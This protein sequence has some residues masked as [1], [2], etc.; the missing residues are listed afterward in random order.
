MLRDG[1]AR[2]FGLT[3]PQE[4]LIQALEALPTDQ[5]D[6]LAA[7]LRSAAE[8]GG[9]VFLMGNGG[10]FDNARLIAALLR[11]RG[12]RAKLPGDPDRYLEA[13]AAADYGAIFVKGLEDD[14][15][16]PED[17]A[18]GISGS[19]NSPNVVRALEYAKQIG[20][21]TL[22]LGGR[23]GGR[24]RRVVGD[25]RCL[26]AAATEMEMIEDL[27]SLI[28]AALDK[29]LAQGL[30]AAEVVGTLVAALRRLLG[31]SNIDRFADL[32]SEMIRRLDNQ[33]R[34]FV[35]GT[36]LSLGHFRADAQRGFT[37]GVPIRG[38]CAPELFTINSGMATLNDDGPSF[39]IA[40]GLV[41]FSP[42]SGDFAVLFALGGDQR[43]LKPARD[44]LLQGHTPFLEVGRTVTGIDFS[45][46][47]D[48]F[49]AEIVPTVCGHACGVVIN[50]WL[51][52][53]FRVRRL[54]ALKLELG[55]DRKLNADDTV[56]LERRLREE[57]TLAENE[58][59][60][61]QYGEA[62]AAKDPA[63][64]G[65]ERVYY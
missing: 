49:D 63:A 45:P 60:C 65:L 34:L 26:L 56:R 42:G 19:G 11:R 1:F 27:H 10:S 14:R 48:A 28:G 9:A 61:F 47:L 43:V 52:E 55:D 32:A 21:A 41:K 44:L 4:G 36:A 59:I 5:I 17:L 39:L 37:N 57:G 20:A 31:A 46:V 22:G 33:G 2:Y 54:P 51:R 13:T 58:V 8:K 23:D 30:T 64:F 40:D 3:H 7:D 25:R 15:I 29:I 35:I 18:I 38:F 12:V 50:R 6:I 16:G 53:L 24:M 62:L